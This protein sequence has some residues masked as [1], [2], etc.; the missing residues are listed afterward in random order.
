[1]REVTGMEGSKKKCLIFCIAVVIDMHSDQLLDS[2][3]LVNI[4]WI[5]CHRGH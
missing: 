2:F 1:M 4:I 5:H 3:V